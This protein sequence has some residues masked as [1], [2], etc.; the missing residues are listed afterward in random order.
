[1][2]E[3]HHWHWL[4]IGGNSP[5][6]H[7]QWPVIPGRRATP[8]LPIAIQCI[9]INE[10]RFIQRILQPLLNSG[11]PQ[12]STTDLLR[13]FE[14]SFAVVNL[15]SG[16]RDGFYPVVVGTRVGIHRTNAGAAETQG[17]FNFPLWRC[18]DTFWEALAYMIVKG[19][20]DRMPLSSVPESLPTG[21]SVDC[22]DVSL[23]ESFQRSLQISQTGS[24]QSHGA[25]VSAPGGSMSPSLRTGTNPPPWT[26]PSHIRQ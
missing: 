23:N 1:M 4:V 11:P 16:N 25:G 21:N 14:S 13:I 10:A 24:Q 3:A 8:P 26:K 20:E 5:G 6:I 22:S 17:L 7:L 19:V 12:L 18:T 15:L 2:S 9:S